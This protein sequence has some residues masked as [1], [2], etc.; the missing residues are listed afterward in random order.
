MAFQNCSAHNS[1]LTPP[2]TACARGLELAE[3]LVKDLSIGIVSITRFTSALA[4][5][6][7]NNGTVVDRGPHGSG[8]LAIPLD[9]L[10]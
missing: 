4:G 5:S 2:L 10:K 6:I 1:W 9:A 8:S 7:D 3:K